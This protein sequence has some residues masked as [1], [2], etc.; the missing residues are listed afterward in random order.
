MHDISDNEYVRLRV[1]KLREYDIDKFLNFEI[2]VPSAS[3]V[4]GIKVAVGNI[5]T[6]HGFKVQSSGHKFL[7]SLVA[8]YI[9]KSDYDEEE[10][11]AVIA[12]NHGTSAGYVKD[13]IL[14]MF[15]D[16]PAFTDVAR[17]TLN[18]EVK[19]SPETAISDAVS[20]FGA[21]FVIY[22]N[23]VVDTEEFSED[24]DPAVNF[25]KVFR[26]YGKHEKQQ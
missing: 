5:L 8:R 19:F 2:A 1:E 22:Y 10:A 7:T 25:H 23:Y 24:S 3:T 16:N 9:V 13:C 18:H 14:G 15:A 11:I 21:L 6:A 12:K 17:V 4:N 26:N 20:I